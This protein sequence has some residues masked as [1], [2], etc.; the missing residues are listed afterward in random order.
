MMEDWFFDNRDK[1]WYFYR[2]TMWE[3][4]QEI[5]RANP[6]L[7]AAVVPFD[8]E[9]TLFV[10]YPD[11]VYF[12][13]TPTG[14][15]E[16][17]YENYV[18]PYRIQQTIGGIALLLQKF[19]NSPYG[20]NDSLQEDQ[21]VTHA[22][23]WGNRQKGDGF[24]RGGA[25][26]PI[27]TNRS[28]G[29]GFW[30]GSRLGKNFKGR[31]DG[32]LIG[33]NGIDLG[34]S[35]LSR[36]YTGFMKWAMSQRMYSNDTI[37]GQKNR[38]N[39]FSFIPFVESEQYDLRSAWSTINSYNQTIARFL[40][41]W[42]FKLKF[43][44][45]NGWLGSDGKRLPLEGQLM[46]A[47][48]DGM[49]RLR[50][51]D[52]SLSD[53]GDSFYA[54]MLGN[55]LKGEAG[56]IFSDTLYGTIHSDFWDDPKKFTEQMVKRIKK[57]MSTNQIPQA[58]GQELID[59]LERLSGR[60]VVY[61]ESFSRDGE[62]LGRRRESDDI[63]D[64]EIAQVLSDSDV[65]DIWESLRQEL[66]G[67][68]PAELARINALYEQL[69]IKRGGVLTAEDL[70]R[71]RQD[72]KGAHERQND[73]YAFSNK[74]WEA[75]GG[76]DFVGNDYSL[77]H[78][79][80]ANFRAFRIF[81]HYFAEFLKDPS[82][83]GDIL[84]DL[85]SKGTLD[86][87]A[88]TNFPPWYKA[89][90]E[91]HIV[92]SGLD[93]VDNGIV[94]T[95]SQMANAVLIRGP[96]GTVDTDE[97]LKDGTNTRIWT[98]SQSWES[99]PKFGAAPFSS[100]VDQS[101]RRLFVAMEP[102]A[103]SYRRRAAMLTTN[104]AAALRPMYRGRLKVTGRIL[105]PHDLV[106]VN[107]HINAMYG[108]IEVDVVVHEFTPQTG[109]LTTVE[110]HAFVVAENPWAVWENN[111]WEDLLGVV[112]VLDWISW[113]A[114]LLAIFTLGGSLIVAGA[115]QLTKAAIKRIVWAQLKKNVGKKAA[116]EMKKQVKKDFV[117]KALRAEMR[118]ALVEA[119]KKKGSALARR[120]A[121][122]VKVGDTVKDVGSLV[123]PLS[124]NRVASGFLGATMTVARK[125]FAAGVIT[126][127][128]HSSW[129][130]YQAYNGSGI[131][132]TSDLMPYMPVTLYPLSLRGLPFVAGL[133]LKQEHIM[134]FGHKAER[135][136]EALMESAVGFIQGTE[137][138]P[139]TD[140]G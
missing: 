116:Q 121:R 130:M 109:W 132:W 91:Y 75:S 27:G 135:A 139:R 64:P 88:T 52:N 25:G 114:F 37:D 96:D 126:S 127:A 95:E 53:L 57:M 33:S 123:I 97:V 74:R 44:E 9:A 56:T 86:F 4:T 42:F 65:F 55:D 30:I 20:T 82:E 49:G 120:A 35:F 133:E 84:E 89:F 119:G 100:D 83:S 94:A 118:K 129:N 8:T 113:A 47:I 2:T 72:I 81:V 63:G 48:G 98:D 106:Y 32:Q 43:V 28:D 40:V 26:D 21:D 108:P 136:F 122:P 62:L 110:P 85:D 128:F 125:T 12:W 102:N 10:G 31:E 69:R 79:I 19:F 80:W 60:R 46:S 87:L 5:V 38:G 14:I 3:A 138:G 59:S 92:Q 112:E 61:R 50:D 117:D 51:D 103:N 107:D 73:S 111:F 22:Q 18:R 131:K 16:K 93:I 70:I 137:P 77:G 67:G 66:R 58:H 134:S 68:F 124:K 71:Q 13:R 45:E 104:M 7:I 39:P 11:Q 115:A 140:N 34:F 17:I 41:A 24:D 1:D 6:G 78:M 76:G 23:F 105:K 15:E 36:S 101:A 54:Q 90:R 99:Y 29:N